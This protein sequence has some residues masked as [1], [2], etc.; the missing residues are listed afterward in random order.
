MGRGGRERGKDGR[1]GEREGGE[2]EGQWREC[3]QGR[4][5]S[6]VAGDKYFWS[7]VF[8]N[9]QG[10]SKNTKTHFS[11]WQKFI[12]GGIVLLFLWKWKPKWNWLSFL[13]I[14][15]FPHWKQSLFLKTITTTVGLERNTELIKSNMPLLEDKDTYAGGISHLFPAIEQ[16]SFYPNLPITK[17]EPFPLHNA[18]L[19]SQDWSRK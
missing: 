11:T 6:S 13:W 7:A 3:V 12:L 9:K 16:K 2:E 10:S 5:G 1:G 18:T 19:K 8:I 14:Y 17:S 4:R 15:H